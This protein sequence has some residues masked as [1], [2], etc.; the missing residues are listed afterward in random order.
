MSSK[1]IIVGISGASGVAMGV[2]LLSHLKAQ[3]IETHLIM[4]RSAQV[5]LA[6]ETELK[7]KDV[8]ALAT[9]SYSQED[10]AAAI[11]SGSFKTDGMVIVPCS[12]RTLAE[13]A[14]GTSS[15]LLTRAADVVLKERRRL[16]LVTRETPLH[17]GH[18]RNMVA[19]TE[20]GA[21]VYPP[22]PAF[23]AKPESI[24][25]MIDHCLGRVMDLFG[26]DLCTVRRWRS[27]D[28][29]AAQTRGL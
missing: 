27:H 20:I 14:N 13:V 29:D 12:M 6:Y 16:V 15:S 5:T 23:Y 25:V 9:A 24:D 10:I 22:V 26:I 4:S 19:A 21:I 18:L 1:R 8:Q 7:V 17:L 11:A 2:R 28:A 3:N